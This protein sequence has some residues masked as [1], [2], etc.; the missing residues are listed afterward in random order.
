MISSLPSIP[1]ATEAIRSGSLT[2]IELVEFC[3]QRIRQ[4]ESH[5][6]AWVFVDERGALNEAQRLTDMARRGEI[7]G[8]LHGIPVGIKDIM[9]VK[10]WPTKCGSPMREHYVASEDAGV[11][12]K[13]RREGAIFLGKTVTTEF[14]SFDPPPTRNPW[15]L[16]RTPGGSSSGSAASVALEMCSA[17]IGSQ[18]GGSIIRPASYCGVV[19]MKPSYGFVSL[20]GIEPLSWHMDHPGPLARSVEDTAILFQILRDDSGS[21]TDL[22]S[23][24]NT[25][26]AFPALRELKGFFEDR[27]DQQVRQAFQSALEKLKAAGITIEVGD[28]RAVSIENL[29]NSHRC[30]MAVEA[31][32][33]HRLE[34]ARAPDRFGPRIRSLI[35][36][37]LHV[38][39]LDYA[40][41]LRHQARVSSELAPLFTR[42][43]FLILP[44]TT[45]AAP[46]RETTGDPAFNSLWSFAG[47]PEITIPCGL[48]EDGMPCGIQLVGPAGSDWQLLEAASACEARL[49]FRSRPRILDGNGPK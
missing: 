27:A 34:F 26:D 44:S 42:D 45:T 32:E 29:V 23:T 36:D 37:G 7:V 31:A 46:G 41:A 30:I 33:H 40:A 11:V 13:L 15:N 16:E 3:L 38:S 24:R 1:K 2:A 35:D 5:V 12:Q 49:G 28:D 39:A 17:A 19:G 47:V 25:S 20:T 9:D 22:R 43:R 21:G 48:T 10:A 14:A 6:R 4:F 18:T 8:R